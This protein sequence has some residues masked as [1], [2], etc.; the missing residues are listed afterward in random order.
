V[1]WPS[2]YCHCFPQTSDDLVSVALVVENEKVIKKVYRFH[3]RLCE[4]QLCG[5]LGLLGEAPYHKAGEGAKGEKKMRSLS[6]ASAFIQYVPLRKT[7]IRHRFDG[8]LA[9]RSKFIDGHLGVQ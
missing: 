2:T 5:A 1:L 9:R 3:E 7:L 4:V 6:V 8:R